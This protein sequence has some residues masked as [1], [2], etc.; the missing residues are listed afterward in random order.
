MA[1]E[2][3]GVVVTFEPV[4][5]PGDYVWPLP[6]RLDQFLDALDDMALADD[7]LDAIAEFMKLPV[8]KKMPTTLRDD[9]RAKGWFE[10]ADL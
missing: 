2:G 8:A 1:G 4:F 3:E 6:T 5:T 7:T 9:L 10:V